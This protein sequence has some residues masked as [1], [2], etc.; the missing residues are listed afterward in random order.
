[1]NSTDIS[2]K[3]QS[4]V[5]PNDVFIKDLLKNTRDFCV[6]LIV[7]ASLLKELQYSSC[8]SHL[9]QFISQ[10]DVKSLEGWKHEVPSKMAKRN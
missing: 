10:K 7:F 1:M 6:T 5:K 2:H 8:K 4:C 9:E 3:F